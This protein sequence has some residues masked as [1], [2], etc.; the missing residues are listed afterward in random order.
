MFEEVITV[1]GKEKGPT[2]IILAGIH[3]D[4]KCG[5]EAFQKILPTL[6]IEK[7][8]VIFAYGNPRAIVANKRF[9]EANLNRMFKHAD[10]LSQEEKESYE[11]TRAQFLKTYLDQADALLDLHAS[12]VPNSKRFAICE[13]NAKTIA[14]YLPVT[15]LVSGFDTVEPGGT[16]YYMNSKGSTGICLECGYLKDP[17]SK[18][19]AEEGIFAFLKS[20]GHIINDLTPQKQTHIHMYKK[21]FAKTTSFILSKPFE[22]FEV[23]VKNQL[24]GIDGQEEIRTKKQ[25]VI[26]FAHNGNTVH[27]EVFLL[28]EKNESLV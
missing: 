2:S 21:Y 26:L 16:D 14:Q 10:E 22:N 6:S 17:Q 9:V 15:L 27:D 28:G 7:G 25:C 13:K 19:I 11:Y 20:R 3:G 18:Q 5:V 1:Q 24:I 12:S 23:I 4:E 8:R